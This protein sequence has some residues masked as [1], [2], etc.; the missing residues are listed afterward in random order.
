MDIR[1]GQDLALTAAST[2]GTAATLIGTYTLGRKYHWPLLVGTSAALV[3][4]A[5]ATN[6]GYNRSYTV[7]IFEGAVKLGAGFLDLGIFI[8]ATRGLKLL[9]QG[10]RLGGG[11]LLGLGTVWTGWRI[12][13]DILNDP[14]SRCR[15]PFGI[16]D[17]LLIAPPLEAIDRD[18]ESIL[19]VGGLTAISAATLIGTYTLGRKYRWPLM[20]GTT[21]VFALNASVVKVI[22]VNKSE[23]IVALGAIKTAAGLLDLG[24]FILARKG[25]SLFKA[26]SRFRGALLT[27]TSAAWGAWRLI[28]HLSSNDEDPFLN[29]TDFP[30]TY[31]YSEYLRPK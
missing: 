23:D 17:L 9:K 25:L 7:A 11:A 19:L 21:A 13:G 31:V 24:A 5:F 18:P 20:L 28:D 22:G 26:G 15:A 30:L 10:S 29:R 12:V 3:A 6:D 16:T 8:L 2:L 14:G 4:N 1:N 27:T